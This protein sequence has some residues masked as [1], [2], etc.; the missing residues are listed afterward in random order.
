MTRT[1]HHGT[2]MHLLD[3][4]TNEPPLEWLGADEDMPEYV[5]DQGAP[6]P[7]DTDWLDAA[8]DGHLA[9]EL[10]ASEPLT[11]AHRFLGLT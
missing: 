9:H 11:C 1:S 10:A 2:A 7:R 3:R 5:L 8:L 4:V 6:L